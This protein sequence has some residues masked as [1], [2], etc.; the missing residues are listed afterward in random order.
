MIYP[1]L[2]IELWKATGND[3]YGQAVFTRMPDEK[4]A[5]VRLSFQAA[6]TT[7]RTDSA[8]SRGHAMEQSANVVILARPDTRIAVGDR[9]V[10]MGNALKVSETHPRMSVTGTLDHVQVLCVAWS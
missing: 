9:L 2:K 1:T 4:V 3:L 6:H 7:V 5:P 10:V 8:A